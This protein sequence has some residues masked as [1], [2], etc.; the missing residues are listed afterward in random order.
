MAVARRP[1]SPATAVLLL[2][3]ILG[4]LSCFRDRPA[5]ADLILIHGVVHTGA[6]G[7]L[8][9]ASAIA[10]R[11]GRLLAVGDDEVALRH[12]GATTPVIDLRGKTVIPGL[13]DARVH[14]MGV[15][16][17]LLNDATGGSLY[18][19]LSDTQS[20]EDAV[21]R[22]RTRARAAGPGPWILGKGWNQEGWTG[23]ELPDKRLISDIVPFNP[24]L[25]V[26]SDGHAAWVNRRALD[27][28]GIGP[29]TPDPP[30][31]RIVRT[32]R[33][34]DPS[35]VLLE[36]AIEPALRLVPP[37]G[38]EDRTAALLLA[39]ERFASMGYT[40]VESS[41]APGRLGLSDLGAKGEE[42]ADLLRSLALAGRLPVRVSLLVAGPSDAA[43]A[44]LRRG[45]EVGVADGRLDIRTIE[46]YAD[47]LLASRGGALLQPYAD[48]AGATGIARATREEIAAWAGRGL[49][50]GIQVSVH[51]EGD[52]AARAAAEGFAQAL[53]ASPGADARFRI[54]GPT[55]FDPDDLPALA[56][57]RV[58]ACVRPG[59]LA[60]G[61]DGPVEERRVGGERADRLFAFGTLLEAG[62]PLC[63]SSGAADHPPH[64]LLGFYVAVT[65]QG[66]DGRPAGGWHPAQRLQRAE[67]LRLFT[68]GAAYAALREKETGTLEAGKWADFAVLS[69]DI[70]EVPEREILKTEVLAT[71]VAG[72]EVY[73]RDRSPSGD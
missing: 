28:A 32:P 39:L 45:P 11:Q 34:G 55:L 59:G 44:L 43:E 50:R 24:V 31:G 3:A 33:S 41:S 63:G 53:A 73:R 1:A 6:A 13:I 2:L 49:R 58:I 23:G 5:E 22:V 65:R 15:G 7:T 72:V 61:P 30:G 67:A 10:V 16:E 17:A 54:D 21:Q 25:L 36:R 14:L 62:M 52:A 42:D 26:R 19:D 20:E 48:D 56:R 4:S 57:A 35:G 12:R 40:L 66:A 27:L 38:A 70:L 37:L 64:P 18:V 69:Q 60:P 29:R 46:L 71:Y 51:A 9:P 8:R 47:G 68:L